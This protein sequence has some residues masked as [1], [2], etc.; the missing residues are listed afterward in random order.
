MSSRLLLTGTLAS[1]A[2]RRRRKADG[3][4]F[5]RATVRDSD[6]GEPRQWTVY[7]N[8][9]DVIEQLEALRTGS[10]VAVSGP[11]AVVITGQDD[12]EYRLTAVAMLDTKRKKKSKAAISKEQR[13]ESEELDLAPASDGGPNDALPF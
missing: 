3:A 10:S 4:V 11:F 1:P 8:D 6:R 13:V 9:P 5:A 7:A 12:L 2:V